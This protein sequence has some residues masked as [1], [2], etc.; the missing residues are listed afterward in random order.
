MLISAIA[1]LDILGMDIDPFFEAARNAKAPDL[2]LLA[3]DIYEFRNPEI[4]GLLIDFFKLKKWDCPIYAV[5]GNREFDEDMD[6]VRKI[7]KKKIIFLDDESA[8]LKVAGKKVGIVGSRGAL[9]SPT[10]WQS[11]NV[12][13]IMKAYADRIK[14]CQGLLDGLKVDVKIL[15]SHYAPTYRTLV[16]ESKSVYSGLGSRKFEEVLIKSKVS[17]AVHGHAHYGIPLAFVE[18]V[19]VFNVAFEINR[20]IVEIDTEKLPKPGLHK[21]VK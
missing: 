4:Y 18:S 7:C 2:L 12:P 10:W 15:L 3:G 13:N 5:I 1:D 17:F 16:G 14:K 19:P 8:E 11:K 6:D 20:K 21:F 9:D